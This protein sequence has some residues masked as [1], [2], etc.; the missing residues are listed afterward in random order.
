[1]PGS[2]EERYRIELLAA[3]H[4]RRGFRCGQP[5]L[6]EYLARRAAQDVKRKVASV[7]VAA[8]RASGELA[9]FYSLSMAAVRLGR[10]PEAIA[11]KLP[12]YP[13]VP[14]VRLGRLAV[15]REAQG[16]GLGKYLL[17]DAL[18][19]SLANEI[20]WAAFIVDAK[21]DRARGWYEGLGFHSFSDDAHHLYLMRTTIDALGLL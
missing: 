21:D 12:R 14:A 13:A 1:M 11:K 6:E 3:H 2:I 10:L 8:E 19:R 15:A 17:L 7:F 5:A 16:R 4:D 18:A 20:A 9:G